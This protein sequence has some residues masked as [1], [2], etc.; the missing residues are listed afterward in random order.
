M[1]LSLRISL[2][3]LY[4]RQSELWINFERVGRRSFANS[5]GVH[6]GVRRKIEM[7]FSL[8]PWQPIIN[9]PNRINFSGGRAVDFAHLI[10][11]PALPF[12]D[13]SRAQLDAIRKEALRLREARAQ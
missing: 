6:T 1:S 11:T 3:S 8:F 7:A 13:L 4:F 9:K 10:P 12:H 5:S 2:D